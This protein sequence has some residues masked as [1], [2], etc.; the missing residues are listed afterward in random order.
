MRNL[1]KAEF[2]KLKKLTAYRALLII[3]LMI[4]VV[5]NIITACFPCLHITSQNFRS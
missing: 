1:I 3:Y 5:I 2:F 4:E